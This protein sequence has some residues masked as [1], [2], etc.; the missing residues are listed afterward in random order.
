[1]P[2]RHERHEVLEVHW[3]PLEDAVERALEGGITDSKTIV[4]LL[5]AGT[6]KP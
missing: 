6:G 3:I 2:T 5:R 4:G 1:V